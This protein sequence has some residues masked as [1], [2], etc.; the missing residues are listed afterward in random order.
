MKAVRYLKIS[1]LLCII[2]IGY[3]E[4]DHLKKPGTCP[5]I[6]PSMT[7]SCTNYYCTSD[8]DC[9]GEEKCCSDDCATYSCQKPV[10][11]EAHIK[12]AECPQV[13]Y[14]TDSFGFKWPMTSYIYCS[15]G[16]CGVRNNH[17]CCET[18]HHIGIY[19]GIAAATVVLV[20]L[21]VSIS[22]C[23]I[24]KYNKKNVIVGVSPDSHNQMFAQRTQYQWPTAPPLYEQAI[25]TRNQ[26]PAANVSYSRTS[27]VLF[28]SK[29]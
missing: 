5:A 23:C 11:N 3:G 4:A 16:C 28:D 15:T 25:S 2:W 13:S 26:A 29:N 20:V 6:S 10:T 9:V 1:C 7:G 8:Y 17:F 14:R 19:V 21:I 18:K 22:C 12:G 27:G 24:H